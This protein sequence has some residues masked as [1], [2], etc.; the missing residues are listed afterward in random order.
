MPRL[1]VF[2]GEGSVRPACDHAIGILADSVSKHLRLRQG[3]QSGGAS[4]DAMNFAGSQFGGNHWTKKWPAA[5]Q[6]GAGQQN[7]HRQGSMSHEF[8]C[9]FHLASIKW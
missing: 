2:D 9:R 8:Y 5:L 4:R 1:E 3:K 6:Q 7:Q